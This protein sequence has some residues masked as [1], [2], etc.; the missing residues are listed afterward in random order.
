MITTLDLEKWIAHEQMLL[1]TDLDHAVRHAN[2]GRW[3][4]ACDSLAIRIATAAR[5]VGATPWGEC[6]WDLVAG[7]VYELLCDIAGLEPVLPS[8]EEAWQRAERL[9]H[10]Y[11]NRENARIHFSWTRAAMEKERDWIRRESGWT[12]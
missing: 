1:W 6:P 10:D 5:L 8:D 9:M 4:M 12:P 3:S 11:P 7:G 2:N